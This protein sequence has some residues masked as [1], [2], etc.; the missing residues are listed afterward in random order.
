MDSQ[1]IINIFI[2]EFLACGTFV[3]TANGCLLIGWGKRYW[4]D[5]P[6]QADL[7]AFY[8]PDFFLTDKKPW[9]VH[10]YFKELSC[11]ELLG[12]LDSFKRVEINLH[13]QMAEKDIFYQ[14]F[15]NLQYKFR[16]GELYKAVPYVFEKSERKIE[17]LE[18]GQ[19]VRNVLKSACINPIYPY[20]FWDSNQGMVGGTPE[21]LFKIEKKERGATITTL[22]CAGTAPKEQQ[23]SL[24]KDPKQLHEHKLVI[25]GIE[26]SL[27]PLGKVLKGKLQVLS[28]PSLSHL[29]TLI[30][31]ETAKNFSFIEIVK[32]LHPTPAL[33]AFPK[34]IGKIWLDNYQTKIDRRRFGAPV[35]YYY[36]SKKEG[37]CF[38]AI[39]NIQW[40]KAEIK[41][42]AGCGVVPQSFVDQEWAEIQLK[43]QSIK[44]MICE[45]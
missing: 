32:M 18:I 6:E 1:N 14:A 21:L 44:R 10:E 25:K 11:E 26:E 7:P 42:G 27:K 43:I 20:G 29:T 28:L 22:A 36:P 41:I 3:K 12:I 40:E 45:S 9:F 37:E 5:H 34:I 8:F 4:L 16:I 15:K 19:L 35:G 30:T 31:L 13:W 17:P 38:V 33:G 23:K 39:R 2:Q 24:L